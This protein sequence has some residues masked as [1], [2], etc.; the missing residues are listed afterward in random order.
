MSEGVTQEF[1]LPIPMP[2]RR[3]R[4][5]GAEF[6]VDGGLTSYEPVEI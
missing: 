2:W 6:V 5:G 3:A 1:T 4:R